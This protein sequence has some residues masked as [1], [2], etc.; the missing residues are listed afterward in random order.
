M[1]LWLKVGEKTGAQDDHEENAAEAF[2]AAEGI[3]ELKSALCKHFD[4]GLFRESAAIDPQRS[5]ALAAFDRVAA[6]QPPSVPPPGTAPQD[7]ET[8]VSAA[9]P[10]V[11]R[12]QAVMGGASWCTRLVSSVQTY[13]AS[14]LQSWVPS[15]VQGVAARA[16][17]LVRRATLQGE[18]RRSGRAAVRGYHFEEHLRDLEFVDKARAVLLSVCQG[19]GA[20]SL[21]PPLAGGGK[22]PAVALAPGARAVPRSPSRMRL[23]HVMRSRSLQAAS[24]AGGKGAGLATAGHDQVDAHLDLL[25]HGIRLVAALDGVVRPLSPLCVCVCVCV[26]ARASLSHSQSQCASTVLVRLTER[27][28]RCRKPG[29]RLTCLICLSYVSALTERGR[30]CRK[31]GSRA[32]GHPLPVPWRCWRRHQCGGLCSALNWAPWRVCSPALASTLCAP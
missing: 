27:G 20:T 11:G 28:R 17:A 31:P 6:A 15:A 3:R 12:A 7:M 9:E 25:E 21:P 29:S 22:S 1:Y 13:C 8:G 4:L 14:L 32:C 23:V 19:H 2:E 18:R 16:V 24:S 26:C 10:G 30:R 5:D